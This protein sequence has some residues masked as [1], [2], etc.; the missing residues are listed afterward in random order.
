MTFDF[1]FIFRH[2]PGLPANGTAIPSV[3]QASTSKNSSLSGEI[4]LEYIHTEEPQW[5]E[6]LWNHE[7]MFKTGEVRANDYL[8]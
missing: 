6:H 2:I 5:L 7:N 3:T 8:P 4:N 1:I